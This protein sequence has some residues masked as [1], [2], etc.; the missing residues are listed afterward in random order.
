MNKREKANSYY[1]RFEVAKQ[2]I[3]ARQQ[4]RK[5]SKE[6]YHVNRNG[7]EILFRIGGLEQYFKYLRQLKSNKILDVGVGS[8]LGS[9]EI[10][11]MPM[12]EGFEYH[13][14]ALRN[15]SELNKRFS[16][17][18]LHI[19]SVESLKGIENSSIAGILGV[20][21]VAYSAYPRLAV[22]RL[23]EVL[24]PGGALKLTFNIFGHTERYGNTIFKDPEQFI[25]FINKLGYD[26]AFQ[27]HA[28]LA[29][30]TKEPEL[31]AMANSI[32]LAIKPGN[33]QAPSAK[34]LLTQ[35]LKG[36]DKEAIERKDNYLVLNIDD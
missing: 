5:E 26:V 1:E 6:R 22:K 27:D 7:R 10:S 32:V 11:Q 23:D 35:D 17:D 30:K 25:N 29:K 13:V 33:L 4:E 36:L 28:F 8:G 19:T 18:R 34:D 21:S 20:N 14:S 16:N 2:I 3:G 24:V 15:H 12:T 31:F 9:G